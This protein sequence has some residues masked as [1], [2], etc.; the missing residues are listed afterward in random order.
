[1][2]KSASRLTQE[3][4]RKIRRLKRKINRQAE[5]LYYYVMGAAILY[6]AIHLLLWG[7]R[8]WEVL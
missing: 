6:F 7:L 1:M 5:K 8:G 2:G 4:K 3:E